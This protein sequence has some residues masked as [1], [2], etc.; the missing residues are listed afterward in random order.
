MKE[1]GIIGWISMGILKTLVLI[2]LPIITI[3]VVNYIGCFV[4]GTCFSVGE[5]PFPL[6]E[7]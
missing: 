1:Q 3:C 2:S 6:E 7:F 5:C 4:I